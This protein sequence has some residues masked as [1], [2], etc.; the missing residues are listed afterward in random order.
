MLDGTKSQGRFSPFTS[1]LDKFDITDGPWRD[2]SM[3]YPVDF[4]DFIMFIFSTRNESDN[5]RLEYDQIVQRGFY[6]DPDGIRQRAG[7]GAGA[8]FPWRA[9]RGSQNGALKD[10]QSFVD[11]ELEGVSSVHMIWVAIWN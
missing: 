10:L 8:L 2:I 11:V 9:R 1:I 4:S 3:H 6:T 7:T 5:K